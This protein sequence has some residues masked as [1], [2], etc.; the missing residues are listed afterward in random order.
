MTIPLETDKPETRQ[1]G[2]RLL[3]NIADEPTALTAFASH[4]ALSVVPVHS[5]VARQA[6]GILRI[7]VSGSTFFSQKSSRSSESSMME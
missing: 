1:S 3:L 6:A 2:R 7:T 5:M 4:G